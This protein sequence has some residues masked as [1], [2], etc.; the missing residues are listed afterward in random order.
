MEEKIFMLIRCIERD[1]QTPLF[2]ENE[3]SAF[4]EML[5]QFSSCVDVSPEEIEGKFK[6]TGEYRRDEDDCSLTKHTA[7]SNTDSL[8][9]DWS[10]YC[11]VQDENH[12]PTA[13]FV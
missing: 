8:N 3:E 9:N 6:Q 7:Y 1:I 2:F 4:E 13:K 12:L 11:L 10:M 5:K